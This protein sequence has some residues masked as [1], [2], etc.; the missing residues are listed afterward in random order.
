MVRGS[1]LPLVSK[2]EQYRAWLQE[3]GVVFACLD[4]ANM[5]HWQNGLGWRFFVSELIEQ[6]FAIPSVRV[7]RVYY[8]KDERHPERSRVLREVENS[9]AVLTTKPL[10]Y[11]P[12]K[13]NRR[14]FFQ[15]RTYSDLPKEIVEKIDELLNELVRFEVSIEEPKCNFD[16][17]IAVDAMRDSRE[18]SAMLLF[19]GDSDFVHLV[20]YLREEGKRVGVVGVRGFIAN[21][22][23]QNSDEFFDFGHLYQG[24]RIR[25]R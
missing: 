5:L 8:G 1:S 24:T 16:V 15:E 25:F 9:G 4:L 21:E 20:R 3:Q 17:E 12:K 10:K 19:F 23:R 22:L 18:F 7:V 14:M 2:W 6:L 11:V 13:I